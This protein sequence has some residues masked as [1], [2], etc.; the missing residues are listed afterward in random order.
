MK[1]GL[2]LRPYLKMSSK[3]GIPLFNMLTQKRRYF[4]TVKERMKVSDFT[5]CIRINVIETCN[6]EFFSPIG[7]GFSPIEGVSS[8][9]HFQLLIEHQKNTHN[10]VYGAKFFGQDH[11]IEDQGYFQLVNIL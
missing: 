9:S 11:D 10:V 3:K 4:Q 2:A 8:K 5:C 7:N 1:L 6:E